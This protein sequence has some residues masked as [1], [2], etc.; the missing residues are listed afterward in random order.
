M[1][2][3]R[4]EKFGTVFT[5]VRDLM[6]SGVVKQSDKPIWYDVYKTFPP[7]KDPLY[8]RP[9][10]KRYGKKEEAVPDIFYREDEIRAFCRFVEK[11]TEFESQGELEKQSLFEETGKALLAEGLG[12]RRRG[13]PAVASETR[14]PVLGMKL[15]DM[16]AEQQADAPGGTR[17]PGKEKPTQATLNPQ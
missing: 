14:N 17:V 3:S 4:L 6:R 15:T 7:M 8:V 1:A 12:L 2:G 5:R 10:A 9:V 16:L 11:Y 13:I